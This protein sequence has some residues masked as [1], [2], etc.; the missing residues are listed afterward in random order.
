[1]RQRK[2]KVYK[3]REDPRQTMSNEEFKRHFRLSK[4]SV[5]RLTDLLSEDLI[6]D[7]KRGLPIPPY[8]QVCICLNHYA[9]GMFQRTTAW[10][11][12]ISQCGARLSLIRVT[13]ALIKRKNQFIFMPHSDQMQETA[14]R[15]LE[16]FQL[17]RF[18]FA[19]DRMQ[20]RF[21]EAPRKIPANKT[22][23][24]FWCRKQFYAINAQVVANDTFIYDIDVGWPGSTHDAR[25][26]NRSEVKRYIEEQR[27]FLLAGD[28]GYPISENLIKPYSTGEAG[29]DRKKRLFNRR[30]SGLRTVMSEC[31]YGAWKRRFPILKNMRTDFSLSQKI[32]VATGVL[33][34]LARM[35]GD[36]LP[37][38]EQ[39]DDHTDDDDD[40]DGNFVVQNAA[41]ATIRLRGQIER[42]ILKDGMPGS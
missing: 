16:K 14:Q 20:V 12:G 36:D 40:D 9:G 30:L 11:A 39:E 29:Q 17:P 22:K 13:E 41:P 25:V 34:N 35:W 27:R 28:T 26:W 21:T 2:Q 23:Q 3:P 38:E 33:A 5:N 8:L 1:M 32:I 4:V 42:D 18:A 10:C 7:T 24:M 19:V 6:F 15:M 31:I 37:E